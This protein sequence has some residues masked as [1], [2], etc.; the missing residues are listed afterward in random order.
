MVRRA[1]PSTL[2]VAAALA[3]P[4]V[5]QD[6]PTVERAPT[7]EEARAVADA[8]LESLRRLSAVGPDASA[9][10]AP[11]ATRVWAGGDAP[12]SDLAGLADALDLDGS[13]PADGALARFFT[14]GART[15]VRLEAVPRSE[16][17]P[18]LS[19]F[20]AGGR[21]VANDDDGGGD[22]AARVEVTLDPG[23]YC[24]AATA[25]GDAP[26]EVALRLGRAGHA[27]LAGDGLGR[28]ECEAEDLAPI[29]DAP[30]D[31]EALGTGLRV[32]ASTAERPAWGFAL[33]EAV[34][35]TI[36]A[37]SAAGDPVIVLRDASGAVFAE[38]DDADGTDSRIDLPTGLGPGDYCIEVDDLNG[39]GHRVEIGLSRF[40][41][42]AERRRLIA[43]GELLPL[44]EDEVEVRGLGTVQASLIADVALSGEAVWASFEVP[45][46]GVLAIEAI[47]Q[48]VDPAIVLFDGVGRRLDE[49]DD[50]PD[51]RLDSLLLRR[52]RAG[53]YT[54]AVCPASPGAVGHARLLLERFEPAR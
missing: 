24:L 11:A 7:A 54:V 35:L 21:A 49:N 25:Y 50:G 52:V 51:G 28:L 29:G 33:A 41:A 9:C 26:V 4:A 18:V 45:A 46:D 20:D 3:G 22:L 17:D 48:G 13:V 36:T 23:T 39:P 8:V 2:A 5:A 47:G 16:G 1:R 15:D 12:G 31:A 27:P 53:R 34:P 10:D 37:E 43:A 40:D 32:G 6:A 38:N 42:A 14:L 44:P 19:V 30:L